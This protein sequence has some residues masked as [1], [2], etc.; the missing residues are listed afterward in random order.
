MP[1]PMHRTDKQNEDAFYRSL[2]YIVRR[3]NFE[4]HARKPLEGQLPLFDE[5]IAEPAEHEEDSP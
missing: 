4:E 2:E 3:R 5:V 1:K